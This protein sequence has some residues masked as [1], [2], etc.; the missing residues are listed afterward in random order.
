M[1]NE[2]KFEVTLEEKQAIDAI[3]KLTKNIDSFEDIA[4]KSFNGATKAFDVFKGALGAE[5]VIK[6]LGL[7]KD[8]AVGLFNT[9]ATDGVSAAIAQEAALNR[10]ETALRLSGKSTDGAKKEFLEYASAIQETT[11][12]SDDLV[13]SNAALLQSLAPLTNTGLKASTKAAI[14]L[15]QAL[16]VSLETAI[17]A[18][19]AAANGNL[20]PLERLTRQGF[21]KGANDAETFSKALDQVNSRFGGTAASQ[22]NTYQGAIIKARN[23]FED[24]IKEGGKLIIENDA[25]KKSINDAGNIFKNLEKA[26]KDNKV[27]ISDFITNSVNFLRSALVGL[28]SG[29]EKFLGFISGAFLTGIGT[30]ASVIGKLVGVFDK[31]LGKSI[32]TTVNTL[33]E[34]SAFLRSDGFFS[35]G[36]LDKLA[37]ASTK[38]TEVIIENNGKL[39]Q[40]QED[41]SD[42]L[43]QKRAD[44]LQK[45][46]DTQ[47]QILQIKIDSDNAYLESLVANLGAQETAQALSNINKL[48]NARDD[49]AARKSLLDLDKKNQEASIFASK[50]FEDKTNKEK[51]SGLKETFGNIASLQ[52]ESSQELFA[53]GKAAAIANAT[54]SGIEATQKALTAAPPPFNF[55][56]AALVGVAAAAN[57]AKIASSQPPKRQGGGILPGVASPT[58]TGIFQGA[59]GELVLNR[60]QQTNLF[61]A[62][63]QNQVGASGTVNITFNDAVVDDDS[64]IQRLIERINDQVEFRNA[65]LA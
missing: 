44:D 1:A 23:S 51:L 18:M 62:I 25:V 7:V 50:A 36:G 49:V 54:I 16:G 29:F 41:N 39:L 37:A 38:T 24:F 60:R 26:I 22:L 10:L 53:I 19:G 20:S 63:N 9:I 28:L 11:G 47:A 4:K 52:N 32:Q 40:N 6:G 27:A 15:S 14:D 34:F 61:N 64:R 35:T 31:D 21:S 33:K 56:L 13:L 45:E 42:F 55:A 43:S 12:V 58:D 8:A 57:I 48:K 65:V 2:V 3:K 46:L 5:L 30:V 59:P 17:R